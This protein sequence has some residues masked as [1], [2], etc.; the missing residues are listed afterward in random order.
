MI[1]LTL[2]LQ[3]LKLI[4]SKKIASVMSDFQFHFLDVSNK[5]TYLYGKIFLYFIVLNTSKI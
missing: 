4:F 1:C 3:V 2:H 5:M